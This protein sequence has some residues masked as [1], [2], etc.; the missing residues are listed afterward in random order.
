MR[1]DV[2][3]GDVENRQGLICRLGR[4]IASPLWMLKAVDLFGL[5]CFSKRGIADTTR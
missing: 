3:A 2:R 1:K 4:V 5:P